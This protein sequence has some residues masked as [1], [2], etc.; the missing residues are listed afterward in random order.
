M[1]KIKILNELNHEVKTGVH[2]FATYE[3][4]C[5]LP[6]LIQPDPF[7]HNLLPFSDE[8]HQNKLKLLTP[9]ELM[10]HQ[11]FSEI[12]Q[13]STILSICKAYTNLTRCFTNL[14]TSLDECFLNRFTCLPISVSY[15]K[16]RTRTRTIKKHRRRRR[17]QQNP[18]IQKNYIHKEQEKTP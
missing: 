1:T 10:I 16:T 4:S 5:L 9:F 7:I 6:R 11:P 13:A 2:I 3:C 8:Q 15:T 14:R 18:E 12:Y 17:K